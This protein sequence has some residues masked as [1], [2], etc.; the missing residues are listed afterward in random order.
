[1]GTC[2]IIVK[3]W[4][5]KK[6]DAVIFIIIY[7]RKEYNSCSFNQELVTWVLNKFAPFDKNQTLY[8]S[9]FTKVSFN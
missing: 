6:E 5:K 2:P 1:M 7:K 9:Y 8:Y 3:N 4:L